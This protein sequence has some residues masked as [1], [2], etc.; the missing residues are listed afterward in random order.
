MHACNTHSL[1]TSQLSP[2]FLKLSQQ[3]PIFG[4]ALHWVDQVVSKL[5]SI[6]Q[7]GSHFLKIG[8]EFFVDVIGCSFVLAVGDVE[9]QLLFMLHKDIS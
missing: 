6:L 3:E 4:D 7:Q 2:V 1:V 5:L 8:R 9:G